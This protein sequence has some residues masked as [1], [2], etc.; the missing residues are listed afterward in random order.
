MPSRICKNAAPLYRACSNS[1]HA[2]SLARERYSSDPAR[3]KSEYEAAVAEFR[4]KERLLSK[5][6][7]V[8]Q[9]WDEIYRQV[10]PVDLAIASAMRSL[11]PDFHIQTDNPEKDRQ[12]ISELFLETSAPL[13][14]LGAWKIERALEY[15]SFLPG[16]RYLDCSNTKI[17]RISRLAPHLESLR[18]HDCEYLEELPDELPPSLSEMVISI[19]EGFCHEELAEWLNENYP[20][21]RVIS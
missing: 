18:C 13:P 20:L 16:L 10:D 6:S 21:V 17:E 19:S 12:P 1:L 5:E 3:G 11:I 2:V 9:Y 8:F 15:A 7:A 14:R 4:S